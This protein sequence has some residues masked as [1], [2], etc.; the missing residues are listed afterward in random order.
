MHRA[1]RLLTLLTWS[2]AAALPLQAAEPSRHDN[3]AVTV[4]ST[5][6]D[7]S[8][9]NDAAIS[10]QGITPAQGQD[11]LGQPRTDLEVRPEPDTRVV[12]SGE[13]QSSL[14]KLRRETAIQ[15]TPDDRKARVQDDRDRAA[16]A[17]PGP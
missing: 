13:V 7:L 15:Q 11:A 17:D 14:H 8:R 5:L 10:S 4:E 1:A 9:R 2:L 6:K 3:R 16:Q 12:V